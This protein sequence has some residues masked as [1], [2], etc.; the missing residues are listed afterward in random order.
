MSENKWVNFNGVNKKLVHER[1]SKEGRT[2][3]SV[4]ISPVPYEFSKSGIANI[5]VNKVTPCKSDENK[6][7]ISL[8]EDWKLKVSVATYYN[9][10]E[11]DKTKYGTVEMTARELESKLIEARKNIKDKKKTFDSVLDEPAGKTEDVPEEDE[12]IEIG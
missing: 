11:K 4:G 1:Q 6:V 8:P 7:N 9:K 5:T 3:Y 12:G 2:Y 10:D